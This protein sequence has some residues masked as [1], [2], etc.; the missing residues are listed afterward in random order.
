MDISKVRLGEMMERFKSYYRKLNEVS[1]YKGLLGRIVYDFEQHIDEIYPNGYYKIDLSNEHD[2]RLKDITVILHNT[3]KY[4]FSNLLDMNHKGH[5]VIAI[6][7]DVA[8]SKMMIIEDFVHELTH[9]FQKLSGFL[10]YE[11]GIKS[12]YESSEIHST[13]ET[14]QEAELVS[15][16]ILLQMS[17]M[18]KYGSDAKDT[19]FL[20][21][22]NNTEYF[23]R[24]SLR[25]IL[26]HMA[27]LN[28]DP[29]LFLDFRKT[30]N[31]KSIA[32]LNSLPNLKR[33]YK[34]EMQDMIDYP[35]IIRLLKN[36]NYTTNELEKSFEI[37]R[38]FIEK[39]YKNKT[40]TINKI[41]K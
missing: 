4:S 18:T 5:F 6:S 20:K 2:K 24:F 33:R 21:I 1:N 11:H 16:I 35:N 15:L 14:E 32:Y 19:A 39:F 26:K 3:F 13:Y 27:K 17:S 36:W 8:D 25:Y 30:L 23:M 28:I 12:G 37:A 34:V 40:G 22:L 41:S 7:T 31:D 10:N 29:N 38:K 9:V